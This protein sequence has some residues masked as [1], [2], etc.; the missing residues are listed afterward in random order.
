MKDLTQK[1]QATMSSREI[2]ELTDKRH[3]N[4]MRDIRAMLVELHG[5]SDLLKFEG[6]YLGANN[7]QRPCFNLPKRETLILVSGYSVAMRA[8]IIDRWQELESRQQYHAPSF[9][10]AMTAHDHA[11][12]LLQG[13]LAAHSLFSCPLHLAQIESVK[14]VRAETGVDFS[15]MLLLAPAQ[16]GVAD[17]DRM[18]EP[19]ELAAALGIGSAIAM[20]RALESKGLQARIGGD[21]VPTDKGEGMCS[22]HSWSKGGKSGY[23]LK[24]NLNRVSAEMGAGESA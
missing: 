9:A 5:E 13:K 19:T 3:D 16:Q 1:D 15:P 14:A 20:N 22:R 18:L 17:A 7:E 4:I 11:V 24:W 8:K 6:V 23:N 21:W 12:N 2:A 10:P